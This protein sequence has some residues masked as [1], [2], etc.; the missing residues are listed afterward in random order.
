MELGFV[1]WDV[2]PEILH[3]GKLSIRYY[4]LFWSMGLLIGYYLLH[5][6]ARNEK[7]SSSIADKVALYAAIGVLI[8]ARLGHCLIYD[9]KYYLLEHPIELFYFW[10][11]GLAS[12]GGTN[13]PL[14]TCT[15]VARPDALDYGSYLYPYC[16]YCYPN[17]TRES[18]E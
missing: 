8:G 15:T 7:F 12:H 14:D 5:R 3:F 13:C 9:P 16:S 1:T 6:F 11:G 10:E 18:D 2:S 4:G 17:P